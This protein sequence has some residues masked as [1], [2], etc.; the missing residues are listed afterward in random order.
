M[1]REASA[2]SLVDIEK[3]NPRTIRL[4][5][6]PPIPRKLDIMPSTSPTITHTAALFSVSV[7]IFFLKIVYTNVCVKVLAD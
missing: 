3:R 6:P 4:I 1:Y 2:D 7:C 5:G